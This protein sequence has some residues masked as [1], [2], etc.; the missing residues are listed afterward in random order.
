MN[1]KPWFKGKRA[2]SHVVQL[3]FAVVMIRVTTT[4]ELPFQRNDAVTY[5]TRSLI[6]W[7]WE[8]FFHNRSRELFPPIAAWTFAS[9]RVESHVKT[10]WFMMMQPSTV[11]P[12]YNEGP[13]YW[14]NLLATTWF[15][16][17]EVRFHIF[18]YYWGKENRL[19]YRGLYHNDKNPDIS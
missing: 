7:Y 14:Q 8:M 19:L 12:R 16:Y 17:I 4:S 5:F 15:R 10:S 6:S 9:H 18:N 13:R 3:T 11:E 1:T 2:F